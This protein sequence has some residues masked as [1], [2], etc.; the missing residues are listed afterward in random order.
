MCSD[1][2]GSG[3]IIRCTSV[4]LSLKVCWGNNWL[5][6][7][8]LRLMEGSQQTNRRT[9]REW[10]TDRAISIY[11]QN[12]QRKQGQREKLGKSAFS[13]LLKKANIRG[14][15]PL[16]RVAWKSWGDS[17]LSV[18]IVWRRERDYVTPGLLA[19]CMLMDGRFGHVQYEHFCF[20]PLKHKSRTGYIVRCV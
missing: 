5:W 15:W 8:S 17:Q 20:I 12:P 19:W 4:N 11:C 10:V 9:I 6:P 1:S 7:L 2:G 16:A 14:N 18:I 3:H 13:W